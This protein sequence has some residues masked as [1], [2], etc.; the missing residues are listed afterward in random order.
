M[1]IAV[2]VTS[3]SALIESLMPDYALVHRVLRRG[4]TTTSVVCQW[5]FDP[6]AAA[7]PGFDPSGAIEFWDTTNREDWRI[8]EQSQRGIASRAYAPGPYSNLESM[9]AAFD[10]EYLAALGDHEAPA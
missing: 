4:P 8:S 1:A 10:R 7:A 9:L 5:L 6:E 3:A 2:G